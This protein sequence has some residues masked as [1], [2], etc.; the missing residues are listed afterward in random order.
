MGLA[1]E[2][3]VGGIDS[4]RRHQKRTLSRL[5]HSSEPEGP[6]KGIVQIPV[7]SPMSI[8][9]VSPGR[10]L[11]AGRASSCTK[12]WQGW[13][14]NPARSRLARMSS[15]S[16]VSSSVRC[17]LCA[18]A[19]RTSHAQRNEQDDNGGPKSG[20][21]KHQSHPTPLG[22]A[23][24]PAVGGSERPQP[25]VPTRTT[26]GRQISSQR[27]GC[28]LRATKCRRI[29]RQGRCVRGPR[30]ARRGAPPPPTHALAV[31]DVHARVRT[32]GPLA[33]RAPLG[34]VWFWTLWT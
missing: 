29:G 12:R 11:G 26:P 31:R 6:Q 16:A 9:P 24:K 34:K 17:W 7:R 14:P 21:T 22:R 19:P 8:F 1:P 28:S 30:M 33:F 25:P 23:S 32:S 5:Q 20:S 2:S 3:V 15:H 13:T 10:R 27:D 18:S 4:V